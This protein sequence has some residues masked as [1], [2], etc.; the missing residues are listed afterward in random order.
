[1]LINTRKGHTE[2]IYKK[3]KTQLK[4]DNLDKYV[5]NEFRKGQILSFSSKYRGQLLIEGKNP[6]YSIPPIS[7]DI[8]YGLMP[9]LT[10]SHICHVKY[11]HGRDI[12]L[13]AR[14]TQRT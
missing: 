10:P 4:F 6:R 8:G 2:I 7:T 1:M 11:R 14:V 3:K 5:I 9:I 12:G 13:M